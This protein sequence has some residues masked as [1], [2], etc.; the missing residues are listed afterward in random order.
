MAGELP[1]LSQLISPVG[2][3]LS[4]ALPDA[5]CLDP[6]GSPFC[7]AA[8]EAMLDITDGERDEPD[9]RADVEPMLRRPAMGRWVPGGPD[10]EGS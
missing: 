10:T 9:G 1:W 4:S 3:P 7:V 6:Y 8:G 2:N 5:N